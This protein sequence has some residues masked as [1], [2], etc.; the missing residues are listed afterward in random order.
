[1]LLAVGTY[2]GSVIVINIISREKMIIGDNIPTFEP[3]WDI[4]WQFGRN[5]KYE[6]ENVVASFDDG[7]ITSY[8]VLRKLEVFFKFLY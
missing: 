2:I 4:S 8:S 7:R 3:V 6:Q 1:M 5:E